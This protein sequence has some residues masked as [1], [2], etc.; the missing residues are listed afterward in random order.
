MDRDA[1]KP[2]RCGRVDCRD[3]RL[4]DNSDAAGVEMGVASGVS[5]I[6]GMVSSLSV[7]GESREGDCG[8]WNVEESCES[9]K[10]SSV[11]VSV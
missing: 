4:T 3:V 6:G 9:G 7:I 2:Y 5:G 10:D 1:E 8:W 11:G